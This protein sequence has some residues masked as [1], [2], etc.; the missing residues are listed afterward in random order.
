MHTMQNTQP[1]APMPHPVNHPTHAARHA[2][3]EFVG[4]CLSAGY[5]RQDATDYLIRRGDDVPATDAELAAAAWIQ[6]SGLLDTLA[7]IEAEAAAELAALPP[8]VVTYRPDA[9]PALAA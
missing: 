6:E 9:F 7:E 3:A 8:V 4:R 2:D 5:T 1:A